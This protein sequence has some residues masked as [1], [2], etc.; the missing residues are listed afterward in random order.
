[1]DESFLLL[2][3]KKEESPLLS[4]RRRMNGAFMIAPA[5]MMYARAR[6][7]PRNHG[8][9]VHPSS[10]QRHKARGG[11]LTGATGQLCGPVSSMRPSRSFRGDGA[12]PEAGHSSWCEIQDFCINRTS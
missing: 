7:W 8:R 3:Y 9:G 6:A 5:H 12:M 1:M 4:Y 2:F 10:P 11:R